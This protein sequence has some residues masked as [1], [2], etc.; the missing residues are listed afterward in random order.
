[1]LGEGVWLRTG[2]WSI[3]SL[4]FLSRGN[5]HRHEEEVFFPTDEQLEVHLPEWEPRDRG[6][7]E[8][9]RDRTRDGRLKLKSP[10]G[11][12]DEQCPEFKKMLPCTCRE[13]N[14][15]LDITC[16]N[17]QLADLEKVTRNLKDH[18]DTRRYR[19]FKQIGYFKVRNS[20][21]QVLPD[22]LFMGLSIVHLTFFDCGL[23]KLSPNSLSSLAGSL[24]HLMLS[25][26]ELTEVPTIAFRQLRELDHVNLNQNNITVLKDGAF[27]GLSKVTRLTLYDNK[28]NKIHPDAFDGLTKWT[29]LVVLNATANCSQSCPASSEPST[30]DLLRLNVARNSLSEV[31]SEALLQLKNLNQ[32][33]LSFNKIKVIAENTFAGMDKLDTLNLNNNKIE[34]LGPRFFEGMP[35][36]TSLKLDY[37]KIKTIH[38]EAFYGLEEQLQSLSLQSNKISRFPTSSL[39]P[40]HQLKTLHL[41]DNN[42]STLEEG[43]FQEFGDHLQN[44]WLDNNRIADIPTPTFEDLT[45]LEWLKLNNNQLRSLPYELVEPILDTVK[46]ID[47]HGNPLVCDCEMKW[48]KRWWEGD[49]QK[50]DTDHIKEIKCLSP[51]DNSEHVMKDVDIEKFFCETPTEATDTTSGGWSP[52]QGV[53]GHLHLLLLLLLLL[54]MPPL[55]Q[56]LLSLTLW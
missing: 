40:L 39:R 20:P 23:Q 54:H 25:N 21:I 17:V 33:D 3:L 46:H 14:S 2:L 53:V 35:R 22:Y 11:S 12:S 45:S 16:E 48:Y 34:E 7:R 10:S 55:D 43:D 52:G 27:W 49:W 15:G 28:I 42:V 50:I 38:D 32:L 19:D 4:A 13:K 29:G 1:M 8:A 9:S 51:E 36:V 30:G 44:L 56:S 5:L 6:A 41:N 31:P 37:N 26:N 24:N 47:I 18:T